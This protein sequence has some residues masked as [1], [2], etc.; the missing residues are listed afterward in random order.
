MSGVFVLVGPV[1]FLNIWVDPHLIFSKKINDETIIAEPFRYSFPSVARKY[2]FNTAII[3][4][5]DSYPY[6][7]KNVRSFFGKKHFNFSMQGA[8]HFEQYS[9]ANLVLMSKPKLTIVWQI[10]WIIF[11]WKKG[12]SRLGS[13]FPH[14]YYTERFSPYSFKNLLRVNSS[15][16]SVR[17]LFKIKQRKNLSELS[18]WG[19]EINDVSFSANFDSNRLD[20]LKFLRTNRPYFENNNEKALSNF[21]NSVE[22]LVRSFPEAKFVFVLPPFHQDFLKLVGKV[23]PNFLERKFLI[24]REIERIAKTNKNSLLLDL[25]NLCGVLNRKEV[26]KDFTH[27]KNEYASFFAQKINNVLRSKPDR[28]VKC[29]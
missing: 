10:N 28:T 23:E 7:Q 17:I 6:R 20:F 22:R 27:F 26:F 29:F 18:S 16:D 3:G 12:Y 14:S 5:S 9:L 13:Q 21:R 24:S 25:E 15:I 19:E 11:F 4:T 1:L 8:T 2:N